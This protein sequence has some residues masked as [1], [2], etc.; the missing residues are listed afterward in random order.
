MRYL[1]QMTVAILL[2]ALSGCAAFENYEFGDVSRTYCTSTSPQL[3]E[4]IKAQLDARGVS[5]GVDYCE[6]YNWISGDPR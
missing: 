2:L 1:T 6:L 5:V 4:E 3:R